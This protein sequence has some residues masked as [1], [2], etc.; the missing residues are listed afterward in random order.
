MKFRVAPRLRGDRVDGVEAKRDGGRD[1]NANSSNASHARDFRSAPSGPARHR[2]EPLA[3]SILFNPHH[4]S[5]NKPF[6]LSA[7]HQTETDA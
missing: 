5:M 1:L 7:F 4:G 3:H 2:A 6:L